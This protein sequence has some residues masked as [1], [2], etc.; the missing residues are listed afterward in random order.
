MRQF[1][2]VVSFDLAAGAAAGDRLADALQLFAIAASMGSPESLIIPPGLMGPHDLPAELAALSG[3]APGSV[4]L[5][6]GLEDP[7][8]LIAD[9]AQALS[10][11]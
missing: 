6:M 1:G 10:G 2:T 11:I 3:L 4:R 5:S 9:L 7:A 8:D